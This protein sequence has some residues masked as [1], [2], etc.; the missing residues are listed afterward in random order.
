MRPRVV[1]FFKKYV[2]G[3]PEANQA[4]LVRYFRTI[5]PRTAKSKTMQGDGRL[6]FAFSASTE[7][8]RVL[9]QW[10]PAEMQLAGAVMALGSAPRGELEREASRLSMRLQK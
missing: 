1:E 2:T 6:V 3:V 10:F 5:Q 8:G 4:L 9:E 7:E